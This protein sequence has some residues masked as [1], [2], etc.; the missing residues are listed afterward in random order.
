LILAGWW[1]TD[2]EA[3]RRRLFQQLAWARDHGAL[4]EVEH[5]LVSLSGEEWHGGPDSRI[6][7]W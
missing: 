5:L 3:K 4:D 7:Q 2:D 6:G 1:A